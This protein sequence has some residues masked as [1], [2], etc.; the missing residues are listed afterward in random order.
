MITL[1]RFIFLIVLFP[2][3]PFI[4]LIRFLVGV[5]VGFWYN[6]LFRYNKW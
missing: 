1:F 3:K 4:G 2:L 6:L 5:T